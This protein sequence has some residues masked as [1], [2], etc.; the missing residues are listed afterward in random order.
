MKSVLLCTLAFGLAAGHLSAQ[1]GSSPVELTREQDRRRA[2]DMLGIDEL[3]PGVSARDPDAPNPANWDEAKANPYPE[4]P[5]P[6]VFE[7]GRKVTSADQWAARRAEL[8]ELF[9][10]EIYGRAPAETPTVRWEILSTEEAT[11][12]GRAVV[13]KKLVGRVDNSSYPA[14][15]VNIDLEV[16]TPADAGEPV[17]LVLHFGSSRLAA[18]FR[19]N[20]Q[21]GVNSPSWS[22]QVIANG[23][24]YAQLDPNSIQADNGGG[25]TQGIIGLMNRGQPRDADDWG[26]LRAWGWGA[27]RAMDYLETDGDVDAA[28]VV[29]EGVSRYGKAALVTIAYEPRLAMVFAGSSGAGGAA[30]FRRSFGE[31]V[32]NV[33]AESEYHWMASNFLKY[34]GPLE[35]DDL[36][37]DSH[38]LIALAAPRPVFLSAGIAGPPPGDGWVDP[39]GSFMAAVAAGPVYELLGKKPLP[40]DA[41]PPIGTPLVEGDIAFHQHGG[42]HT[43]L[44]SWPTF[45]SWAKRY[46]SR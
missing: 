46:W 20:P 41:F 18:R 32:E 44:P 30:L 27:S 5:D 12:A 2:L 26:S 19:R 4:L 8:V 28:R 17:P 29:I 15:E 11:E 1:N 42:G 14:V 7:D 40:T 22:E 3:R 13:K 35:W 6:L 16:T 34:A 38:E 23:W 37:V 21:P 39:K 24:S 25:L 31:P 36:P 9:D 10:R 45:L 33:A 43:S